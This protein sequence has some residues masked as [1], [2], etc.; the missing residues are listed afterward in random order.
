MWIV[1]SVLILLI[2]LIAARTAYAAGAR[3]LDDLASDTWTPGNPAQAEDRMYRLGYGGPQQ[4]QQ[5][6]AQRAQE[7]RLA[8]EWTD[9]LVEGTAGE[10]IDWEE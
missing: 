8:E 10:V 6:E 4:A 2:A 7:A 3:E 1:L 9:A 5:A